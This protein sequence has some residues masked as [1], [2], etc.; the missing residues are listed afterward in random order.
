M[1]NFPSLQLKITMEN[2]TIHN[3]ATSAPMIAAEVA[4]SVALNEPTI[5]DLQLAEALGYERLTDIRS[6]IKRHLPSLEAMGLVRQATVPIISGKGRISTVTE[7]HLSRAQTAFI[8][9]KAKTKRAASVAVLMAEVFAMFTEGRLVAVDQV[10][11]TELRAAEDRE[12]ERR[13]LI[14]EEE[15]EARYIALR[16]MR[17]S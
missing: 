17:R 7:Y 11:D 9:G 1:V 5:P 3:H 4:F 12:R 8:I 2:M 6:L 10:A 14:H 13:R 16:A 15:K